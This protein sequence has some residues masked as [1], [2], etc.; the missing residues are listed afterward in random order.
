MDIQFVFMTNSKDCLAV[1]IILMQLTSAHQ[2]DQ[3]FSFMV[4]LNPQI[5]VC[6]KN[7]LPIKF[8]EKKLLGRMYWTHDGEKL[9]GI[10][11]QPIA[12]LYFISN[13][14]KIDG[15]FALNTSNETYLFAGTKYVHFPNQTGATNLRDIS[16]FRGLPNNLDAAITLKDNKMYFFKGNLYWRYDD[17]LN[18]EVGYPKRISTNFFKCPRIKCQNMRKTQ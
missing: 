13:T 17:K 3:L 6:Y 11:P 9:V 16:D 14:T 1:L 15:A 2:I 4:Q 10:N 18:L 5:S 12:D 7:T 8:D